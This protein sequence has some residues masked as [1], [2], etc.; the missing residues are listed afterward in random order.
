MIHGF[1]EILELGPWG[2]SDFSNGF[3]DHPTITS[4]L[5]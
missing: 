5:H 4:H 1:A 2:V 3:G